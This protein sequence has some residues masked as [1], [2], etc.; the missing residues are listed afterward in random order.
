MLL[1]NIVLNFQRCKKKR[2]I[3]SSCPEEN[4][5]FTTTFKVNFFTILSTLFINSIIISHH[6]SVNEQFYELENKINKLKDK[7]ENKK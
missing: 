3:C 2:N 5:L 4:N 7:V 1:R 6:H